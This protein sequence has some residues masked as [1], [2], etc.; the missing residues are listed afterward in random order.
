MLKKLI[1]VLFLLS[2]F[3][4]A[5]QSDKVT[6]TIK[7]PFDYFT[8]DNIGNV[9]TVQGEELVKFNNSGSLLKKYSNKRY[10]LITKTDATNALKLLL[11][12]KDFQQ[13]VFLDNQLSQNGEAIS[14]EKLGYEQTE[15]VCSSFNNSF[16]IYNK[17]NNELMRF[18][19][20]SQPVAKTGNL[21][22]LLRANI[23]PNFMLE[24]NS[25]LYLNCPDNG[26]YV[27]DIYGTFTKVIAIK[28]LKEFQVSNNILYYYR[29]RNLTM[30]NS[31]TFEEQNRS[32]PDTLITS[33]RMEKDRFFIG[34]NDS[35]KVFVN[36]QK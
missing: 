20:N 34:Y 25:Y 29:N 13:L 17:Q 21:K 16:W 26:V 33:V 14:L 1:F 6:Y 11:Y 19:E 10:G 2:V 5:I 31:K 24:H 9:Y 30:Y 35:V 15:L 36:T 22:Q 27:F 12:Y 28:G 32:F 7:Q 23:K 3:G 8:T 4:A 18:N